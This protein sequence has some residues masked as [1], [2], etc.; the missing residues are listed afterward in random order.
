MV[1]DIIEFP[2]QNFITRTFNREE[3][4]DEMPNAADKADLADDLAAGLEIIKHNLV[5]R[6][7]A[8]ESTDVKA[9]LIVTLA[10]VEEVLKLAGKKP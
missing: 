7:K 8:A 10:D 6:C 9:A 2:A 3:M 5:E 1:E 4:E